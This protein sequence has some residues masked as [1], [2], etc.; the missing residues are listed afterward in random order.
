MWYMR[1][2]FHIENDTDVVVLHLSC[3]L[4]EH[5]LLLFFFSFMLF[6]LPFYCTWTFRISFCKHKQKNEGQTKESCTMK[7]NWTVS[8]THSVPS[9]ELYFYGS[10]FFLFAFELHC[11]SAYFFCACSR[12]CIKNFNTWTS[13]LSTS[14]HN[15]HCLHGFVSQ[16]W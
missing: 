8:W 7:W 12:N 15:L 3:L 4:D 14:S 6:S 9:L 2:H 1:I 10:A 5:C 11:N 16:L 13:M